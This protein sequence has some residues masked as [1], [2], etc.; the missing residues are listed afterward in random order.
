MNKTASSVYGYYVIKVRIQALRSRDLVLVRVAK[1][2]QDEQ[3][4]DVIRLNDRRE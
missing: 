3:Y 2:P 1:T 4:A